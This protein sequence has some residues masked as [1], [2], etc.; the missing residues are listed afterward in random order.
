MQHDDLGNAMS[1]IDAS[2]FPIIPTLPEDDDANE[3]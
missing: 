3:E 1:N 2:G